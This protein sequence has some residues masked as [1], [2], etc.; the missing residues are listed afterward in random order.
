MVNVYELPPSMRLLMVMHSMS[1]V[2][3]DSAKGSEELATI[4]GMSGG[5]L[6]SALRE[7][8]QYGY[9]LQSDHLYYLS[10]L[11]ICVVRSVYT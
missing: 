11:G 6:D 7:L 2:S 5:E 10:S 3:N 1:A 4:C 8:I 9:V